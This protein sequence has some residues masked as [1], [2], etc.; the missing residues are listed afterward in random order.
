MKKLAKRV[1]FVIFIHHEADY[2]FVCK[3]E[4]VRDVAVQIVRIAARMA[5]NRLIP[6]FEVKSPG[7]LIE[8]HC[9]IDG[10]NKST[11]PIKASLKSDE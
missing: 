6:N 4:E 11:Q 10:A 9:R 5:Q 1:E 8:K 2:G 3:S 7:K